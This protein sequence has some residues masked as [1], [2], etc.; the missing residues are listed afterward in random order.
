MKLCLNAHE[1]AKRQL[2][3]RG[4]TFQALDNG[5]RSCA[6]PAALQAICDRLVPADF[7]G[8]LDRWLEQVPLPLTA[9]DRR[10]GFGYRLSI[11]QLE[12]SRT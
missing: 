12:V 10:A 2:T 5:F 7:L 1:W 9:E 8:C 11:L 4:I 3:K 6:D